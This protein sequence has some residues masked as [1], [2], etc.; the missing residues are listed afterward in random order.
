A[1]LAPDSFHPRH[2]RLR[3]GT[4][5]RPSAT[6]E[7][8]QGVLERSR[9]NVARLRIGSQRPAPTRPGIPAP[10]LN[11][12]NM[13]LL[14]TMIRVGNLERS[15]T[16]YTAVPSMKLLRRNDYTDGRFNLAFIGYKA[17]SECIIIKQIHKLEKNEYNLV[18]SY[19]H[20]ALEVDEAYKV[21]E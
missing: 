15:L 18:K 7:P 4:R 19:E 1:Q 12:E 2:H 17:E 8:Q 10:D 11:G 16:F 3:R 13:R 21:C 20:I 6:N 9:A 5:D 14:H